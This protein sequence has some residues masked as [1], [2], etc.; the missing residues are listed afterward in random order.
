MKVRVSED[1]NVGIGVHQ[2]SALSLYLFI[3]VKDE[4]TKDNTEQGIMVYDVCC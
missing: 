4:V 2:G 3:L 1:F